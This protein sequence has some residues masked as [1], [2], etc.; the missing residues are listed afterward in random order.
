MNLLHQ[1]KKN[2]LNIIQNE[3][4]ENLLQEASFIRQSNFG[5]TVEL[6]S[7]LNA[8]SGACSENCKFCAQSVCYNTE[9]QTYPILDSN[10]ILETAREINKTKIKH[11]SLVTS[12]DKLSKSDFKKICFAIKKIKQNTSLKVCA[13]IGVCGDEE[14]GELKSSGLDRYHHNL[15]TSENYYS[16]ICTTHTWINRYNNIL[17]A[18]D[19]GLEVCSGGLFGIGESWQDRIELA[20]AI[21]KL[22]VDSIPI[23]FLSPI[24]GTPLENQKILTEDEALRIIILFRLIMPNKTIR[25]CGGRP[26]IFKEK[27]DML[28]RAGANALMTGNYLT[29]SGINYESDIKAIEMFMIKKII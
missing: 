8:K 4:L 19:A 11:F 15:E 12:G 9:I 26:I 16:Q 20:L 17:R 25:I 23:N 1:S 10:K 27:Q 14:F 22:N 21:K 3:L 13:S 7:I 6:C 2:N 5:N 28:F 29:T 24:K 18:K